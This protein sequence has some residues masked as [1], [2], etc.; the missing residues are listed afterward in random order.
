VASWKERKALAQ[1]IKPIYT[2]TSAEAA[3]AELD[4][5]EHGVRGRKFPTVVAA[6]RRA[7]DRVIPFFAFPP[8]VR[9]LIY[10]T[11]AIESINAQ[12][13]Q[14]AR[15]LPQRRCCHQADLAGAAQHHGRLGPSG[16]GLEAGDEPVRHPL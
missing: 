12:D 6:W 15:A 7:W 16:Q 8:A 3:Q 14:D 9:R 11:N 10:T 5:F 4:A 1:A 2:A 13:H